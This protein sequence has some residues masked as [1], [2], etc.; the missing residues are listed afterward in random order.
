MKSV[1]FKS[2]TRTLS[3]ADL[4]SI[5]AGLGLPGQGHLPALW[6]TLQKPTFVSGRDAFKLPGVLTGAKTTL[7]TSHYKLYLYTD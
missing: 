3:I 5:L 2:I 7:V 1:M 6:S 4:A